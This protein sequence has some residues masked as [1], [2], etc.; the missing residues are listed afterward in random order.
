MPPTGSCP[1]ALYWRMARAWFWLG[2]PAFAAMVAV[3]V[4]MVF[5][6]I[7]GVGIVNKSLMQE[8]LGDATGSSCRL[9]FNPITLRARPP[10]SGTWMGISSVHAAVPVGAGQDGRAGAAQGRQVPTTVV[11]TVVGKR[12]VWLRTLQFPNGPVVQFNSFWVL[13]GDNQ[14]IEYVNPWLG[15]A[16]GVEGWGP[17]ALPRR[18]LRGPAWPLAAAHPGMAGA[19]PH[20]H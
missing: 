3:V 18:A 9:G 8:A 6:H 5:K 13:H 4:L 1:A 16:N 19:R 20:H 2:I 14:L 12:Q 15:A 10:I 11:K 7:P 17:L